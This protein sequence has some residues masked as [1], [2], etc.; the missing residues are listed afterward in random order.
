M[1]IGFERPLI[2]ELR[3]ELNALRGNWF[4]FVL[5]G[6]RPDRPGSHRLG[7][8]GDRFAG[9]GRGDRRAT[10]PRGH[11]RSRGSLLVPGLE[12]LLLVLALGRVVDRR[13]ALVPAGAGPDG[14]LDA[15]GGVFPHG[16]WD[17]QD[18]S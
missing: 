1:S 15:A 2:A 8:G 12:R 13:R 4:W 16:R 11:G 6:R 3:H 7:L 14:G 10:P 9:H 17:L 5:L 18:R